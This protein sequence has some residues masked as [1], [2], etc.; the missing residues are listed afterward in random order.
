MI[1]NQIDTQPVIETER[2][3]LRPVRPSDA[4]LIALHAGDARVAQT[5]GTIPHP[6]PPGW[7]EGYIARVRA[8]DRTEDAWV[9]D[10]TRA[11][12]AEVLGLVLLKHVDDDVREIGFWV[13]PQFWNTGI[14]TEAVAALVAANPSKCRAHFATVFQGNAASARVLTNTGFQYVG[15]AEGFCVA[16]GVT[17]PTWTYCRKGD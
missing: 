17:L 15:D 7:T 6:L 4:G 3:D 8:P 1:H 12:G 5:T 13:A 11:G 16:R 14:A 9:I 10:A 2:F